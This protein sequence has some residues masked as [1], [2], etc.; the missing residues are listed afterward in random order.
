MPSLIVVT[1]PLVLL[2]LTSPLTVIFK[3]KFDPSF[4]DQ[5]LQWSVDAAFDVF[6]LALALP[7]GGTWVGVDEGRGV[8]EVLMELEVLDPRQALS[9]VTGDLIRGYYLQHGAELYPSPQGPA[10]LGPRHRRSAPGRGE[11]V[12]S[13]RGVQ[14]GHPLRGDGGAYTAHLQTRSRCL[15]R[16]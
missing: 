8:S 2:P 4:R 5:Q 11:D 10:P 9:T 6:P 3:L 14:G 12:C 1:L 13:G 16:Q 15:M 7:V